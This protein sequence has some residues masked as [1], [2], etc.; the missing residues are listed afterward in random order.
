M[1]YV[2]YLQKCVYVC[3]GTLIILVLTIMQESAD[4][5]PAS[6][7]SFGFLSIIYCLVG[8]IYS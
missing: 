4:E 3:L 2:E 7:H 8:S 1:V 5:V 6:T